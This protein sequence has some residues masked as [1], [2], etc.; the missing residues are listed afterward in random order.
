MTLMLRD[1]RS[2]LRQRKA[3]TLIELIIV[4]AI[5]GIISSIILIQVDPLRRLHQARNASRWSDVLSVLESVKRF[6]S[7]NDG[8]LPTTAN[9]IDGLST[10]VQIIGESVTNCTCSSQTVAPSP[11]G[12][13]GLNTD[14]LDY[15]PEMPIDPI[16]GTVND[17]RYYINAD[18]YGFIT[19]GSCGSEGEEWGGSGT[20]P[21]ISI[22][23]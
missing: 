16:S 17:T 7:D 2:S 21:D 18:S 1:T 11:C 3:F 10:S 8:N 6:Q 4:I 19:V 12:V 9:A 20:G 14:L 22:R 23:R 15:I 5:L 13:S